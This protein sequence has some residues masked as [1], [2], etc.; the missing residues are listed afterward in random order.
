M[1]KKGKDAWGV[2]F[3]IILVLGLIIL[4]AWVF[5]KAFGIISSPLWINVALYFGG[6]LT[7]LSIAY[8]IGKIKQ[9]IDYT[10]RK[11]DKNY[12]RLNN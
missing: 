1:E 5:L 2:I 7:I 4:F 9:S 8:Y 11:V 10:D 6:A 3:W 12:N